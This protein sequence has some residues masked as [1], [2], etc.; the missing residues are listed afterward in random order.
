M[1]DL[2]LTWAS[3]QEIQRDALLH[4]V[5]DLC[6]R[7]SGDPYDRRVDQSGVSRDELS[8]IFIGLGLSHPLQY[9][10]CDKWSLGRCISERLPGQSD[11]G[12]GLFDM[13]P[14]RWHNHSALASWLRVSYGY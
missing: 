8:D 12:W 9:T 11:G 10:Q 14:L 3:S 7:R 5:R 4:V 6:R 1:D 2:L 13:V